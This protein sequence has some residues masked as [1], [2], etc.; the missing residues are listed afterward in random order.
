MRTEEFDHEPAPKDHKRRKCHIV[1]NVGD[2]QYD[3][4]KYVAGTLLNWKLVYDP[5]YTDWDLFWTD[6]AVQPDLLQ[7]MK[8]TPSPAYP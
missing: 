5:D 4:I 1:A 3:V 7:R 8:R 2:T 6:S